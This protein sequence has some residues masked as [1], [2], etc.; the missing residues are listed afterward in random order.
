[1]K[2][3]SWMRRL[4]LLA[5]LPITSFAGALVIDFDDLSTTGPG[6]A[7]QVVVFDKYPGV[8]FNSPKA[9]DYAKGPAA[10]RYQGFAHSGSVALEQCSGKEDCPLP[11][12]IDFTA[13]QRHV[14]LW[15]GYSDNL[16]AA[17]TVMFR[18]WDAGGKQV[19]VTSA[20]LQPSAAPIP[21][22]TPLE[23]VADGPSIHRVAL[24]F[25]TV[26]NG[27]PAGSA[28]LAVDDVEFDTSGPLLLCHSL[29]PPA[30]TL[31]QPG[32]GKVVASGFLL[33]GNVNPGSPL[34]ASTLT[35][36]GAAGSKSMDLISSGMVAQSGGAFGP[37]WIYDMLSPGSNQ[38]TVTA[39][40]CKGSGQAGIT[41][42][43][44]Q[45]VGFDRPGKDY[46]H[47]TIPSGG[48]EKCQ[49]AC[50]MDPVCEA[51]TYV[52][53]Q[54]DA[55]LCWLKSDVPA[56]VPNAQ[57]I[58]GVKDMEYDSNRGGADIYNWKLEAADPALCRANCLA[59]GVCKAWTFVKPGVRGPDAECWIKSSAPRAEPNSCCVSGVRN[60][61][62]GTRRGGF[63]YKTFDLSLA[64][65]AACQAQ[66]SAEL[67]CDAWTY[68][69]PGSAGQ[70]A[71]C[72]LKQGMLDPKLNTWN[73]PD[74]QVDDCCVSGVKA[75]RYDA[76]PPLKPY[77][78]FQL[79]H[80]DPALC[81]FSCDI[82]PKCL[83][84]TYV[85]P[86]NTSSAEC[87]LGDQRVGDVTPRGNAC[88]VF[89]SKDTEYDT[90][91]GQ[92][93]YTH[94]SVGGYQ[95][96][97][98]Q[99]LCEADPQCQSWTF[100]QGKPDPQCWLKHD[101]GKA[102]PNEC[103]VSGV[104]GMEFA[105]DRA[106]SNYKAFEVDPPD[107]AACKV[108]CAN[109]SA[110]A[111]WTYVKPGI[112]GSN[113][114]CWLKSGV[115]AAVS[116]PCC[117]SG[118]RPD[119]A[120]KI[121]SFSASVVD[122]NM[123]RLNWEVEY[124]NPQDPS[125]GWKPSCTLNIEGVWVALSYENL[126]PVGS[127]DVPR[128]CRPGGG[129]YQFKLTAQCGSNHAVQ[130]TE[131]PNAC[132]TCDGSPA[133]ASAR[134]FVVI[135]QN[136]TTKCVDVLS[137]KANSQAGAEQC[138]TAGFS[139]GVISGASAY[140]YADYA[141]GGFCSWSTIVNDSW[142]NAETCLKSKTPSDSFTDITAQA[143]PNGPAGGV[144]RNATDS[145]CAKHPKP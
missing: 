98:C 121:K 19:A 14:K 114:V 115:P 78:T 117:I 131:V 129:N 111:A 84:W 44:G 3:E 143:L 134:N 112:Q 41:V 81:H 73:I 113:G 97:G 5:I 60:L 15:V 50:D 94:S 140:Y 58:S 72:A 89:G 141:P 96:G 30:V 135:V 40:D 11:F 69:K 61:E 128:G 126:P 2:L 68:F 133:T 18:A 43:R 34:N 17:K 145:W 119:F 123:A 125:G 83:T 90:D 103:C 93:G 23:V 39:R 110:C 51:Y 70:P 33:Q 109:G 67:R 16:K 64:D 105:I 62:H 46:K 59:H 77:K 49:A 63:D 74:A 20:T 6:E 27:P 32:P 47:F 107:P 7:G 124:A 12:Q 82:D 106:G 53:G 66:C 55:G 21:V 87:Q 138:A 56:A 104:R 57:C 132:T 35:V 28:G 71:R 139:A 142:N 4:T 101:A 75:M 130:M 86:V 24:E 85:K 48:P 102:A 118:V 122:A 120:P 22:R 54:G 31:V 42:N 144:D 108:A 10:W 52:A 9:F 95:A 37:T 136:K 36:T 65:P 137:V 38:V 80:P 91:R 45:E 25:A 1:M 100:A 92:S 26:E 79:A 127:Q 88:C 29:H 8:S 116:N 76:V 13:G 99:A